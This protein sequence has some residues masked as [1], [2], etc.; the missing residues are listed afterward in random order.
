MRLGFLAVAVVISVGC[1]KASDG[2]ESLYPYKDDP[3]NLAGLVETIARSAETGDA[4]KA[5]AL[6]RALIPD[7]GAYRKALAEDVPPAV[8]AAL[9]GNLKTLPRDDA[10]LATLI[11]RGDAT[12][13]RVNVH[14]ATREEIEAGSTPAAGEFPGGVKENARL[15]RPG[16]RFYEAEFVAP[17]ED[18]GMKYHLFF[19]DGKRWRML[20]PIWRSLE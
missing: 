14:G 8:L 1:Q 18:F 16:L 7:E 5:G 12:Q 15:L 17:G 10:Q 20:G 4:K 19:W 13:T 3:E 6:T 2:T 9:V 11:K